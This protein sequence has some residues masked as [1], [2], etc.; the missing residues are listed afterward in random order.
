VIIESNARVSPIIPPSRQNCNL[1]ATMTKVLKIHVQAL[2]AIELQKL[3]QQR[4]VQ[5]GNLH[6]ENLLELQIR[7]VKASEIE[8]RHR[9]LLRKVREGKLKQTEGGCVFVELHG[10]ISNRIRSFLSS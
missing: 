6:F 4:V 1:P 10:N 9:K 5:S 8:D 3:F 7:F 2:L